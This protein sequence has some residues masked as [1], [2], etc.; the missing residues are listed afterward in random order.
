VAPDSVAGAGAGS[1]S[2]SGSG[3]VVT[4]DLVGGKGIKPGRGAAEAGGDPVAEAADAPNGGV[5]GDAFSA[6]VGAGGGAAAGIGRMG[7]GRA[8]CGG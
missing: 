8:S 1:G 6:G 5:A 3:A 2:G 4:W 7:S